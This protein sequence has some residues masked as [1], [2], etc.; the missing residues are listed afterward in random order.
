MKATSGNICP[1]Q[2]YQTFTDLILTKLSGPNF[3]GP[4]FLWINI[5]SG[6]KKFW[7]YLFLS[8]IFL[9][10]K[11]F[12]LQNFLDSIFFL[13]HHSFELFGTLIILVLSF[14]DRKF[15][16]PTFFETNFLDSNSFGPTICLDSKK[17]SLKILNGP[18]IFWYPKFFWTIH[19]YFGIIKTQHFVF[20]T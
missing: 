4:Y 7:T 14:L 16:G 8:L 11:L 15:F 9:D 6:L 2:Q 1:Y 3:L 5:F 19:L 17:I 12:G 10:P 20:L 13:I 18:K